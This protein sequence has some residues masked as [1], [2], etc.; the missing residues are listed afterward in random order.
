MNFSSFFQSLRNEKDQEI[1]ENYIDGFSEKNI[2]GAIG[3]LLVQKWHARISSFPFEC[4]MS[5]HSLTHSFLTQ[6][7]TQNFLEKLSH[8][9][10]HKVHILERGKGVPAKST[11]ARMGRRED[12]AVRVHTPQSFFADS[13]PKKSKII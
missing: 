6:C 13:L 3:L 12:S 8:G 10:I 1:H 7:L 11:L 9:V 2:F 5:K 4:M